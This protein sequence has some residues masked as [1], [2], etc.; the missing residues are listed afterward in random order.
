[1]AQQDLLR[2]VVRSLEAAGIEYMI[3]GS[4]ASSLQGEPRLTHDLDFVV[5]I[6]PD[7]VS[8]LLEAFPSPDFYVSAAAIDEAL[9]TNGMFNVLH[10]AEGDKVD[11]WILTSDPFDRSRFAR[12]YTEQVFGVSLKVSRPEDTILMKLRWSALSG[13]SEKHFQDALHVYEVQ[14]EDLDVEYVERWAD[15]LGVTQEWKRLQDRAELP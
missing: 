12:R 7:H 11:F 13:G 1:V 8:V 5:A 6:A 3:T 10:A 4:I 9:Q 14:A 15:Q 2:T